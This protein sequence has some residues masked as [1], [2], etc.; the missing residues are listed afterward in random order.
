MYIASRVKPIKASGLIA[1]NTDYNRN[2]FFKHFLIL[3]YDC[4][5][6]DWA[7]FGDRKVNNINTGRE[8]WVQSP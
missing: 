7:K 6:F 5:K 1:I 4:Q 8:K 3:V 2:L